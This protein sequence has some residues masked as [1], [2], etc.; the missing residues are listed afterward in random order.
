MK[1]FSSLLA[2][3]LMAAGSAMAA[4]GGADLMAEL[5]RT[6][7]AE[8]AK[9]EAEAAEEVNGEGLF[10]KIERPGVQPSYIYGTFHTPGAIDL[11]SDEVW[12]ALDGAQAAVFE[13]TLDDEAAMEQRMA[14]DPSFIVDQESKVLSLVQEY[15]DL[16]AIK[17]A[18]QRRGVDPNMA[19]VLRPWLQISLLSFPPCHLEAIGSGGEPLDVVMAHRAVDRGIAQIGL[20]TYEQALASLNSLSDEDVANILISAGRTGLQDEDLFQTNVALYAAGQ[21]SLLNVFNQWFSQQ[22]TPEL[23]VRALSARMLQSLLDKRNRD[24]MPGLLAVLGE[25][26]AF[27]GVGALH[28]PGQTGLVELLRAEGYTVTRLDG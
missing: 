10:W 27:V 24:W 9:L 18:F 25:G 28:L 12:Q 17:A 15:D 11:V 3:F 22:M 19:Q 5:R 6:E 26:N 23:D 14:T 7:P 8:A 21:I 2:A 20:E 4:C 13:L 16:V 1:L